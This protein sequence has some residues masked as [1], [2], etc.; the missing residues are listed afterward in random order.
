MHNLNPLSLRKDLDA[1]VVNPEGTGVVAQGDELHA[2]CNA[3]SP[4]QTHTAWFKVTYTHIQ[5]ST[6]TQTA[7]L[8]LINMD[9]ERKEVSSSCYY[10]ISQLSV[11][12]QRK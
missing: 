10:F 11:V 7:T 6:I 4:L 12:N 8:E 1:A 2:T 5:Y 9:S 3:L